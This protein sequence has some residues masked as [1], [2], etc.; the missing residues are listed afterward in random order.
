MTEM[1]EHPLETARRALTEAYELEIAERGFD[2][3]EWASTF[4]RFAEC[5]PRR[6]PIPAVSIPESV[7]PPPRLAERG[8]RHQAR[9]L[10]WSR[11]T[12]IYNREQ[13]VLTAI[14]EKQLTIAETMDAIRV[15]HEEGFFVGESGV[16]SVVTRLFKSHDLDRTGEEYRGR[17]RYR[18]FRR[19]GL[20]GPIA[21]LQRTMNGQ[22]DD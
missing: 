16:R 21:D 14:G 17:V 10:N 9:R 22:I 7:E 12:T 4:K 13:H 19:I 11:D 1:R 20:E 6:G 5:L 15:V 18:Y 2:G 3:Y 8:R